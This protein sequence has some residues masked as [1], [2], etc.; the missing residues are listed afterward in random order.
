MMQEGES[1]GGERE[2]RHWKE[3]EEGG[4][5]GCILRAGC[6][7]IFLVAEPSVFRSSCGHEGGLKCGGALR[8]WPL[9]QRKAQNAW[10]GSRWME[11]AF[12]Y[13]L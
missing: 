12:E 3:K 1:T 11:Q 9:R 5:F 4:A 7:S 8:G 6:F 2:L 10:Y 13:K